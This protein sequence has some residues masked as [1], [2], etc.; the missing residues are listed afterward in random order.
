M[1][2]THESPPVLPV[3]TGPDGE[4][5]TRAIADAVRRIALDHP[6]QPPSRIQSLLEE[7]LSGTRQAKVRGF[8]LLLAE[9]S[10]RHRLG[11]DAR[12]PTPPARLDHHESE[13]HTWT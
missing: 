6:S 3:G 7:H 5:D 11:G 12:P 8:R 4:V 9:R 10:T 13:T 2:L 1:S